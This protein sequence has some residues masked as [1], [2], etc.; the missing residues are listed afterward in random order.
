[1]P[2]CQTPPLYRTH[3]PHGRVIRAVMDVPGTPPAPPGW[4]RNVPGGAP[5]P[6]AG[7]HP[8]GDNLW[9]VYVCWLQISA[10]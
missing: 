7:P 4:G 3:L 6:A 10:T 9:S 5:E 2:P 1:M 8:A